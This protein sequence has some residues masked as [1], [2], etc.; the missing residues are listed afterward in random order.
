M[1][2]NRSADIYHT[3]GLTQAI[4]FIHSMVLFGIINNDSAVQIIYMIEH[5]ETPDKD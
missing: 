2:L 1:I 5:D 4:D 3:S